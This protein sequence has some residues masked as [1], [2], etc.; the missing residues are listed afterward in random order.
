MK[1]K[2][3]VSIIVY[4]YNNIN[5][6]SDSL[7]SLDEFIDSKFENYEIV[8]VND[9]SS[10]GSGI[11]IKNI[12][13]RL[14]HGLT[15]IN[16][17]WKHGPEKGMLSGVDLAIGDF[18]IELEMNRVD[19]DFQLLYDMFKE[20]N[21]GFDIVSACWEDGN[22][23]QN[24]MLWRV[25][26]SISYLSFN[27]NN[28]TARI[29][30]RR[31]INSLLD[32]NERVVDRGILY[33][34][35]GFPCNAI[36]YKPIK[37]RIG[38]RKLTLREK[39]D[40]TMDVVVSYSNVGTIISIVMAFFFSIMAILLGIYA[41]FMYFTYDGVVPG[42]TTTVLFMLICFFG[43]FSVLGVQGKYISSI[44]IEIKGRRPYVIRSVER[45]A[46]ESIERAT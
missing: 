7:I 18:I 36:L 1:E 34:L 26:N 35:S 31:A 27:V 14:K 33:H 3:F 6:I 22:S 40:L 37:T 43:V 45:Y 2:A 46:Q 39:I 20:A 41:L 17:A 19:Y 24:N 29:V 21:K 38:A 25:F 12:S 4:I 13:P 30:S 11:E 9:A 32:M 16:L 44:L 10:D 28:E 42:W 8:V 15:L 23:L 5:L